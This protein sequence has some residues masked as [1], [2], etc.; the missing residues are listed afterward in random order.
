MLIKIF[1]D[2]ES[3]NPTVSGV[4]VI[5]DEKLCETFL[6]KY[7][8]LVTDLSTIEI[9]TVTQAVDQWKQAC[10]EYKTVTGNHFVDESVPLLRSRAMKGE[11]SSLTYKILCNETFENYLDIC[12]QTVSGIELTAIKNQMYS[13]RDV[14]F[15]ETDLTN[16]IQIVLGKPIV[17]NSIKEVINIISPTMWSIGN[18]S[19][20]DAI[21]NYKSKKSKNDKKEESGS[22]E[23]MAANW[24]NERTRRTVIMND[25]NFAS[26]T[27]SD[28][29][30]F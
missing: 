15:K 27:V 10:K 21:L 30:A 16:R 26:G 7:K 8:D 14:F 1:Q 4:V 28:I 29:N 11:I 20:F 25:D 6:K 9:R 2:I 5:K 19:V 24:L 23:K 17:E 3:K 13:F 18:I 22:Y 12:K